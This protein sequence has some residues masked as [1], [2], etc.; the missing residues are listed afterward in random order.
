M[1]TTAHGMVNR[2]SSATDVNVK[3]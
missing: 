1:T 3:Y 2:C